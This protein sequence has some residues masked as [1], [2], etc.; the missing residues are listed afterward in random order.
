LVTLTHKSPPDDSEQVLWI[1]PHAQLKSIGGLVAMNFL[2]SK[3]P[4]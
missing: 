1:V 4:F 2:A 3:V